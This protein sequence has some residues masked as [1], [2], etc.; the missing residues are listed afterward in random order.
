VAP[1]LGLGN[2]ANQNYDGTV[3]LN[4]LGGRYF[5]PAPTFNVYGGLSVI[6]RL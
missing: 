2:L 1:F 3:R 5:E 4:A 6:A